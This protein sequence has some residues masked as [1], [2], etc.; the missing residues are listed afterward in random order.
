MPLKNVEYIT[1]IGKDFQIQ[2]KME[3]INVQSK[4]IESKNQTHIT[5]M[6]LKISTKK[7]LILI[8]QLW[9]ERD[10]QKEVRTERRVID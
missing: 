2:K 9:G 4:T 10:E 1:E 5:R 7:I 6:L 8:L 3:R